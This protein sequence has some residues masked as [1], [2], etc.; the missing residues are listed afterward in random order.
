M[1]T[2]RELLLGGAAAFGAAAV[3]RPAWAATP[4]ASSSAV[5][6]AE[7]AAARPSPFD[8]IIGES[9]AV[10]A[11]RDSLRALQI[12]SSITARLNPIKLFLLAAVINAAVMLPI[13]C[14][15]GMWGDIRL[16]LVVVLQGSALLVGLGLVVEALVDKAPFRSQRDD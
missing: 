2:R 5:A 8:A 15:L 16:P 1:M 14:L 11:L 6:P 4:A 7:T 13:V 9:P 3:G 10:V 12:V